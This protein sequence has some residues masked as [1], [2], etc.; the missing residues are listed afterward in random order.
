MNKAEAEALME[1]RTFLLIREV[2]EVLE[3]SRGVVR[4]GVLDGHVPAT[5]LGNTYRVPVEWV[6]RALDPQLP[7]T[8]QD[9]PTTT[10]HTR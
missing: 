8:D 3:R 9:T 1:G 6:R 5:K 2:A 10:D 4:Q 7:T